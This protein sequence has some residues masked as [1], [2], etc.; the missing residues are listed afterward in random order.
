MGVGLATI[1]F[2]AIGYHIRGHESAPAPVTLFLLAARLDGFLMGRE[3]PSDH[4]PNS[5]R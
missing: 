3:S 1:T 5:L 2:L 4:D